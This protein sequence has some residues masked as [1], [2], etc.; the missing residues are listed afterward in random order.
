MKKVYYE[1]LKPLNK[2]IKTLD[3][4]EKNISE[5]SSYSNQKGKVQ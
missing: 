3:A 2:E 5:I 4:N 1:N